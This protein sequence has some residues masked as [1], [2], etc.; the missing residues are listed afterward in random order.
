MNLQ[1]NFEFIQRRFENLTSSALLVYTETKKVGNLPTFCYD[2][3]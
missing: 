3:M 1:N 2:R